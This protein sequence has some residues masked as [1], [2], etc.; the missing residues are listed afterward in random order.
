MICTD[1]KRIR[2][3]MRFFALMRFKNLKPEETKMQTKTVET[4]KKATGTLSTQSEAIISMLKDRGIINDKNINDEKIRQASKEKKR[5]L[6]QNTL[7]LLQHYRDITWM[8]EC[9]PANIAE[10]LEMQTH[11]LD[12]LLWSVS[13]ELDMNNR[14]L[15]GRLKSISKSRLL[16]DRFNEAMTILKQKP[17]NGQMMYSII[18]ETYLIPEK[19]THSQLIYRLDISTRHYYRMRT[20]AIN[21][22]SLRLWATPTAELGSWLDVLAILENI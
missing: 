8:L 2:H 1:K 16:L 19:L 4:K 14:R 17:G 9:F 10:D 20:Q 5:K 21:I 22:L 3:E 11:N 7:V 12:A 13:D 18:H 6:Y 15:E